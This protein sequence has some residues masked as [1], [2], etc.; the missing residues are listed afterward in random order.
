M[1]ILTIGEMLSFPL[2]AS[3]VATRAPAGSE[4]LWMGWYTV[5]ISLAAVLAPSLGS[6]IYE[7]NPEMVWHVGMGAGLFVFLREQQKAR[8]VARVAI[9]ARY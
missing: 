9:K 6:I 2:S 7:H 3:F 5:T 4:G 1:L 8:R